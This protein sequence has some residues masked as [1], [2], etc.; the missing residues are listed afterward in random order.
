MPKAKYQVKF[1]ALDKATGRLLGSGQRDV[2]AESETN[3]GLM[4][5]KT[6]PQRD[7]VITSVVL[8]K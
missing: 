5:K 6:M 1:N 7:I 2:T 4:V 8:K 3:A